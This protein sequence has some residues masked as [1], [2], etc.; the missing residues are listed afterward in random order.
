MAPS[1]G[2][3]AALPAEGIRWKKLV[4]VLSLSVHISKVLKQ[5]HPDAGI[6]PEGM[7]TVNSFV[8]DIFER[9]A[10]EAA[11]LA[12]PNRNPKATITPGEIQTAVQLLLPGD[13]GKYAATE[14]TN[15]VTKCQSCRTPP[16]QPYGGRSSAAGLLFPVGR[17][18]WH[19]QKGANGVL[20]SSGAPVYLAAVLEYL[21]SE[22]L[23]LAV[24]AAAD[25]A[26]DQGAKE[27][28]RLEHKREYCSI[29]TAI[30]E[31]LDLLILGTG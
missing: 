7:L 31:A 27:R 2:V 26:Y 10:A 20:V 9:I 13:L 23:E 8:N 22:I 19:L 5:V 29:L 4:E 18:H 3:V 16:S 14:G 24:N 17:I 21:A 1:D 30:S 28:E 25:I 11:K 12:Q 6:S 15:A